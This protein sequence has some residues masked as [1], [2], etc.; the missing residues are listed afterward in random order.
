MGSPLISI[1]TATYNAAL[2]F[3][4]TIRSVVN[5]NIAVE[6]I[7]IDGGSTDGTIEIAERNKDVIK[8]FYDSLATLYS[9]GQTMCQD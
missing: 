4:Q 6:F 2:T 1:I 3:E 7:V 5:Q 8:V 9:S